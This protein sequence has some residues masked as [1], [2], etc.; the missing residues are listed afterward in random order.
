MELFPRGFHTLYGVIILRKRNCRDLLFLSLLVIGC[1]LI[2]VYLAVNI[3]N[4]FQA[5]VV[6]A[7]DGIYILIDPGH[8]GI[9]GGASAA[10]GT[11]EKDIN[12]AVSM[13]LADMLRFLGYPVMLTRDVDCMICDP[14]L[15]RIRDQKVSDIKNRLKLY[16]KSRLT[17]S[18]HQNHFAQTQYHGTQIWYGEKNDESKLIGAAVRQS[19][20]GLLQPE[21]KRELKKATRDIYLLSNTTAPA[22]V[23]ECGFLSNSAELAK[24]KDE[25]YR[26]DMAYAIACGILSYKP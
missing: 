3:K 16:N 11:V 23:V 5:S 14:G 20:I 2:A 7:D 25:G 15:T 12:L 8:G 1:I 9:D 17:I 21:N 19:V 26:Q 10:D 13:S 22:I 18:I 24:L 6:E 4:A